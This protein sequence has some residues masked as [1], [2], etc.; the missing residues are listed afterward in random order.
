MNKPYKA[1]VAAGGTGGHIF[2]GLAIAKRLQ[3]HGWNVRWIG[4]KNGM[5][6]QLVPQ[7]DIEIDT[8]DM[9]GLRGNGILRY[10]FMPLFILKSFYECRKIF[11]RENPDLVIGMGGYAAFSPG[12]IAIQ[13][14]IPLAIHEQNSI[15]GLVNKVLESVADIKF[16]AFPNALKGS[17]CVGNPVRDAILSQPIPEERF[18]G[19]EGPLRILILGGSRGA[20]ALNQLIPDAI[21]L[22]PD[23]LRPV[24]TH[25][26][27][28]NNAETVV[29]A[30][31]SNGVDA[32][33]VEFI[34]DTA[35]A[36][37]DADLVIARSGAMTVA[38]LSAVGA[39]SL[40]I[41]F[42][43]AVD[44]HQF[45]NAKYLGDVNAARVIREEDIDLKELANWLMLLD[46]KTC[47]NM[48]AKARALSMGDAAETIANTCE[49][50]LNQKN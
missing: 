19:R 20:A 2:P 14:D 38:E 15:K 8:V 23:S 17:K 33:V 31:E 13:Q 49:T 3:S 11:Q 1:I 36:Y 42:P 4:A 39:A 41:P 46:R 10:L 29:K 7:H 21:A 35:S 47:L 25:Q 32:T 43:H 27:G 5:E 50:Y 22:F 34:E 16:C 26:A 45:H 12:V 48:A 28:K 6:T 18:V 9:V 30:Y 24:I 44:D 37:A 40:L